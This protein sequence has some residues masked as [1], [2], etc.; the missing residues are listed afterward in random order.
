MIVGGDSSR[1]FPGASPLHRRLESPPTAFFNGLLAPF[2]YRWSRRR[3]RRWTSA[4]SSLLFK[5]ARIAETRRQAAS[6][7]CKPHLSCLMLFW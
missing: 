2:G 1:R 5:Q 7:I 6:N 4:G 3:L